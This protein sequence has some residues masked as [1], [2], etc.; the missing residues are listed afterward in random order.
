MN[1]TL[2]ALELSKLSTEDLAIVMDEWTT[3]TFNERISPVL[4]AVRDL[5]LSKRETEVLVQKISNIAWC[6]AERKQ[7]QEREEK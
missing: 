3:L 5:E 7:Q 4:Q 6:S 1:P 2:L